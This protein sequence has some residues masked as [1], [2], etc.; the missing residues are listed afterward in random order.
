[1]TVILD[2]MDQAKTNLPFCAT[3]TKSTQ[4]LWRIRTHITG[5][6]IH[7][8]AEKGKIALVFL[9][10]MEWPHD[11]NLTTTILLHALKQVDR[12]PQVL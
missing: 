7:T 12:L 10:L 1:M 6:L 4:N 5:A 11:S 8:K 9:D 2:G 3:N